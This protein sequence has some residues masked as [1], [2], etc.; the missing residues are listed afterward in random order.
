MVDG[1]AGSDGIADEDVIVNGN[2]IANG[3][4]I[5]DAIT[6]KK[7]LCLVWSKCIHGSVLCMKSTLDPCAPVL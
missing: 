5:A 2:G 4:V 7:C 3:D 6:D 1:I